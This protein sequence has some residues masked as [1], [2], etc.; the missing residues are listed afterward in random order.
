MSLADYKVR[1]D[2]VEVGFTFNSVLSCN[3]LETVWQGHPSINKLN[4]EIKQFYDM[5][6]KLNY[7]FEFYS[8]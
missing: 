2:V 5:P 4:K 8:L 7:S 1:H 3:L 6:L